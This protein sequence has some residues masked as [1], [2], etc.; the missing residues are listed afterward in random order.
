MRTHSAS[1]PRPHFTGLTAFDLLIT[2]AIMVLLLA[3]GIPA[4]KHISMDIQ[5]RAA[6]SR[7]QGALAHARSEAVIRNARVVV[8]P[9]SFGMDCGVDGAWAHGWLT[10]EDKNDDREYQP[11]EPVIRTEVATEN[12][13]IVSSRHRTRIRFFPNGSAPGSNARFI[14]CDRRGSEA[15][16]QLTLSSSGRL[17]RW[18]PA[19]IETD[20]CEA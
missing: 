17:R 9:V 1:F 7:F 4:L 6:L 3:T 19:E 10:F 16:Y 5:M 14:F 18:P 13:R 20:G 12:L 8:C 11:D 15:A 2:L